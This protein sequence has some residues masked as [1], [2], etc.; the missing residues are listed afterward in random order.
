[1]ARKPKEENE[2]VEK[3]KFV[4]KK[5]E[6]KKEEKKQEEVK[7]TPVVVETPVKEEPK[8]KKREIK[9][10]YWEILIFGL[11][12]VAV[13]LLLGLIIGMYKN[14]SNKEEY[15]YIDEIQYVYETVLREHYN[16]DITEEDIFNG[17]IAGMMIYLNDKNSFFF[18]PQEALAFSQGLDGNFVGLGVVIYHG[19]GSLEIT[20]IIKDSPA[21]KADIKVGDKI[22]RMDGVDYNP[23]TVEDM[24][25]TI[26]TSSPGTERTF[27]LLRGDDV[28]TVTV[29]LDKIVIPS[30]TYDKVV[31]EEEGKLIG[32]ISINSFSG[33][34]Y[35]QFL[36][37]YKE[38]MN[39]GMT[40]LVID[41]R[42]NNGG[43]LSSA[44]EISSLFLDKGT[45]LYKQT[46]GK[47]IEETLDEND[48][49]IDIPV[50]LVINQN[51]ASSAE[52]FAACLSENLGVDIVGVTSFGKG[53]VQ[54]YMP[55]INGAA[56]KYTVLEWLTPNG[57][58]I[59]EIGVSPTI[60]IEDDESTPDDEQLNEA[61]R[62]ALEK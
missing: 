34:T 1:M 49:E 45:I 11:L 35:G 51:S 30:V 4:R 29:M 54:K 62:V 47:K 42:D 27:E 25:Y 6:K 57:N 9:C 16:P 32:I 52:V 8:K 18:T 48:K 22:L 44:N 61:I 17:A 55:L 39:Q 13:G 46:D 31:Y 53:T 56:I 36:E 26:Q 5:V 58:H 43:Y 41:V 15:K 59:D 21:S 10:K 3:K 12:A 38:L 14:R 60:E 23:D 20:D 50:V 19:E 2:I 28:V 7:D 40:A 33:N 37:Y 24:I